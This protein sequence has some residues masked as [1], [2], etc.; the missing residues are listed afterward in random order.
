MKGIIYVIACALG[1]LFA[2][3]QVTQGPK[4][5]IWHGHHQKT[6]HLGMAQ[7]DFNVMGNVSGTTDSIVSMTYRLNDG[8]VTPLTVAWRE[9][10]HRRLIA[11]GDFNAD[12]PVHWLSMGENQILLQAV[13]AGGR[14]AEVMLTVE[15]IQGSY[16]LPALIKWDAVKNPQDVGQYVDGHWLLEEKG[17][18]TVQAGYDRIFLIGEKD[19]QDYEVTVP[20]TIHAINGPGRPL[21]GGNGIG[22]LM[23]FAGH[24]V[25]GHRNFPDAQPKWGYQPFG[26]IGWLRWNEKNLEEPPQKQFYAGFNNSMVNYGD[27]PVK[28]GQTFWMKMRCETLNSI[29]GDSITRETWFRKLEDGQPAKVTV[30]EQVLVDAN[31]TMYSFKIWPH[32]APEPENWNWRQTQVSINALARGGVALL[33]HH[34]D[35]T[36]G[37]VTIEPLT[38][39]REDNTEQKQ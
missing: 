16:S 33:A 26:A 10:G 39:D 7:D 34:V 6:G 8:P 27:F 23:R 32:S 15:K 24:V 22:I 31:I 4:I 17:L 37:D 9:F 18:R 38:S 29:Y 3:G 25:G 35:A 21:H 19:W 12:I 20:V 1:L 14:G 13:D 36:F 30:P 5:N 28:P 2:C 11:R